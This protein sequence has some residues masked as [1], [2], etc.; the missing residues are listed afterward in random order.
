MFRS[1]VAPVLSHAVADIQINKWRLLSAAF[2]S[3]ELLK[4][5]CGMFCLQRPYRAD[6]LELNCKGI[7][8]VAGA[9]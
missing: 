7:N 9:E 2:A 5:V 6:G 4:S 3:I 1:D 8:Q